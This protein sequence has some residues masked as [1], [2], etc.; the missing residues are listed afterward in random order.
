MPLKPAQ[1]IID[2]Y[3]QYLCEEKIGRLSTKLARTTYFGENIL[4]QST[5]SGAAD[6][7]P[8]DPVKLTETGAKKPIYQ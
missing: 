6:K 1:A 8:L 3:P 4:S 7:H 5:Y 2:K